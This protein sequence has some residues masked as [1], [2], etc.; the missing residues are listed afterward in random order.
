MPKPI[1]VYRG[2]LSSRWYATAS[3]R[4]HA[5]GSFSTDKKDDVTEYIRHILKNMSLAEIKKFR[6]AE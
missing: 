6:N 1:Q 3:Y 2:G 4:Q 5:D